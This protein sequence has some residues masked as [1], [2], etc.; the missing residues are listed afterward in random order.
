MDSSTHSRS[1]FFSFKIV[2]F[3]SAFSAVYIY[4]SDYFLKI[5]TSDIELLTKIQTFKGLGFILITALMLYFLVK[6]YIDTTSNYYQQIIDVQHISDIKLNH[7]REEYM[8]L[9]NH[10]P[11]PMWIIDIETLQF[12]LINEAACNIYGYTAEEY[13]QLTLMDIKLLEDEAKLNEVFEIAVESDTFS[14][15]RII[16]HKKKDG[17]MIHVK[18]KTSFLIFEGRKVRLAS[19]VD[20]SAEIEIQNQ[21]KETNSRLQLAS[22]IA[23]LGYWTNDLIQ[24]SIQWSDEMY[25]IFEVDSK[26]FDLKFENIVA[27]FHPEDQE[28]F[29]TDLN[30]IFEHTSIIEL[31]KRI[32]TPSGNVKWIFERQYLMK[33]N[34]GKAIK[35]QGI[36]LDI[37]KSKLHE[38][39]LSESNERFELLA[40][41]TVEAII[42]W[43]IANN[44][45]LWG[46]GFSTIFGYDLK[47]S[48]YKLWTKNIHPDDRPRVLEALFQALN[49]PSKQY[50]T[51]EFRFY[52]ANKAIAY[53]QHKGVFIRDANGKAI[54]ALG[55]MIDLTETLDRLHK[56]EVQNKALKDISWTQSHVVR[57][58]LANLM[59][60]ISLMKDKNRDVLK[61]ETLVNYISDSAEQLDTII[62]EIVKKTTETEID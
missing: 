30:T 18:V 52:K 5:F 19:A 31:E 36:T 28:S 50:F 10:S 42:D 11:L 32:I 34:L 23:S 38:Q 17:Q 49:D 58:P 45:V 60:L 8:H 39:A 20:V 33:D 48:D 2:L 35:L 46:E 1:K 59:G 26:S 14:I 22:E 16:R 29:Y 41:A 44:K 6:H 61:D 4:A 55:A 24:S 13:A 12:I 21:L 47:E 15:P 37:T 7:S 27:A 56:I 40:K 9:F 54:R 53:V 62:R 25:K 3:Y 51:A 57:A 43:D